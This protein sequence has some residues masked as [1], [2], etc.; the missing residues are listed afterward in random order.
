MILRRIVSVLAFGLLLGAGSAQAGTVYSIVSGGL[1]DGGACLSSSTGS[2]SANSLFGVSNVFAVT[3]YIT[4]NSSTNTM[5]IDITLGS[6]VMTG[7]PGLGAAASIGFD[8][9]NY[10]TSGWNS[11]SFGN[12]LFGLGASSGLVSGGS[13]DSRDAANNIIFGPTGISETSD[14]T[15]LSCTFSGNM[16]VCGFTVGAVRD[17]SLVEGSSGELLD[18][19]HT[20]NFSVQVIPEP[21]ALVLFIIGFALVGS[22]IRSRQ[23]AAGS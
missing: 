12:D 20:F 9:V 5:D 10:K 18:F 17:F 23:N 4:V 2:C 13:Y 15:A 19:R 1:T 7:P 16:G 8:N 22:Q 21:Q 3:G 6:A 14:F 11:F